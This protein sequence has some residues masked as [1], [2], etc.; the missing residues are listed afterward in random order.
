MSFSPGQGRRLVFGW[1][2]DCFPHS[3]RMDKGFDVQFTH[4]GCAPCIA[5]RHI[6][7]LVQSPR[8]G[9]NVANNEHW[10][11]HENV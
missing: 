9:E 1:P 11:M 5:L 3:T 4:V 7:A 2:Q 10:V 6:V 8:F